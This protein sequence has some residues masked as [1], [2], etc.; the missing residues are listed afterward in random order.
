MKWEGFGPEI[1]DEGATSIWRYPDE[2]KRNSHFASPEALAREGRYIVRLEA[3]AF[4]DA[5]QRQILEFGAEVRY[6][7][8]PL[9]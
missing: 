5:T 4:P 8:P 7:A 2:A 6:G 3:Y 1:T 9:P